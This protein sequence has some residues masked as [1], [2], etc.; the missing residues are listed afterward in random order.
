MNVTQLIPGTVHRNTLTRPTAHDSFFGL[1]HE[2]N[3]LFNNMWNGFDLPMVR[4]DATMTNTAWPT[5]DLI[6]RDK[7][8]VL[9][10]EVPGMAEKDIDVQFGHQTVIVR[11]ERHAEGDEKKEDQLYGYSERYYGRFERRIPLGID[12]V[13]DKAKAILRNGVLTVTLPKVVHTE[14]ELHRIAV[15]KAA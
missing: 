13:A 10:V 12:I 2:V 6:E 9:T 8:L 5:V 14:S 11:G 7:E 4:S 1:Q 15:S 3:R